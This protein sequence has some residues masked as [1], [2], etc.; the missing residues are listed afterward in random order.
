MLRANTMR[1]DMTGEHTWIIQS[2]ALYYLSWAVKGNSMWT[3]CANGGAGHIVPLYVLREAALY[4]DAPWKGHI[5]IQ[6]CLKPVLEH[7]YL[8]LILVVLLKW[9]MAN[10]NCPPKFPAI[11]VVP[12]QANGWLCGDNTVRCLYLTETLS[13]CLFHPLG[14]DF[15]LLAIKIQNPS[16]G[17]G[18]KSEM[19]ECAGCGQIFGSL[20]AMCSGS[21]GGPHMF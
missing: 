6:A 5:Q 7:P 1:Y 19:G 16:I 13:M 18:F 17:W 2:F 21:C 11:S 10:S 14:Q 15:V 3:S 4:H 12:G 9:V 20:K 8:G